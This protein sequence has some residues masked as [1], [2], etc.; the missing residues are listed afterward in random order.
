MNISSKKK[1]CLVS[2]C[3][4]FVI[5]SIIYMINGIVPFGNNTLLF[6]DFKNQYFSMIVN[7]INRIYSHKSLIY[8]FNSGL[9]FPI[10]RDF[11][12][13]LSSPLNIIFI[14]ANKNN[15][16]LLVSILIGLRPILSSLTM[17]Y[18]L[19]TKFKNNNILYVCL[20][21]LY[22]FS[23]YY[24]DYY[25]NIM[26]TDSMV[27][28]P[29][30][31][32]GLESII[33]NNKWKLYTIS[34]S[35]MIFSNYYIAY[36][37]CLF[38][39]VYFIF[40]SIYKNKMH[41][42]SLKKDLNDISRKFLIYLCSSIFSLLICS[43]VFNILLNISDSLETSSSRYLFLTLQYP[44]T[45]KS[46]L[47][48][49][50][51]GS[52][53]SRLFSEP[54][55]SPPI[56]CGILSVVLLIIYIFNNK[57]SLRNKIC[58]LGLLLF[59]IIT[60]FTGP[61]DSIFNLFHFPNDFP[62]RYSFLYIFIL[63]VISSYSVNNIYKINIKLIFSLCIFLISLIITI[64]NKNILSISNINIIINIIL[65]ISYFILI[66]YMKD[67]KYISLIFIILVSLECIIT[68]N[69]NILLYY[70][71]DNIY[72]NS[73]Q[74]SINYISNND[75]NFYRID[76]TYNDTNMGYKY[77]YY[78]VGYYTSM[79][80]LNMGDFMSRIGYNACKLSSLGNYVTPVNGL[81][82]D[83]KYVVGNINSNYYNKI[84]DNIYKSNYESSLMFGINKQD[85]NIKYDNNNPFINLNNLVNNIS[86]IDNIFTEIKPDNININN[87][88]VT[89]KFNNTDNIFIYVNIDNINY[90]IVNNNL[91]YTNYSYKKD[92]IDSN[93]KK[94]EYKYMHIILLNSD[95]LTISYTN[96]DK[97]LFYVYKLDDNKYKLFADYINTNKFNMNVF[98]ED[99]IDGNI[100]L[101][102]DR[103]MYVSIPYDKNIDVYVD[104]KKVNTY[105]FADVLLSFDIDK[106][107]HNIK[108]KYNMSFMIPGIVLS[109]V[110]ILVFILICIYDKKKKC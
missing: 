43:F 27:L 88:I 38:T 15:I 18:Y 40:Y 86:N 109:L 36:M 73:Y 30:I 23:G 103:Q 46:F 59:F 101:D 69:S 7:I 60:F 68:F 55:L 56:T 50:L 49:H 51:T 71:T 22:A 104:D 81:L 93:I 96:Y 31:I 19:S 64:L 54:L 85:N 24:C 21:V 57:I 80:Y 25:F 14:F 91:Y 72:D 9:G 39:I 2:V 8:T 102:K 74:D 28:L 12:N 33:N 6:N 95:T 53:E 98:N 76:N 82:F 1:L 48:H 66:Y 83:V 79:T 16:Y 90:F 97:D 107:Y 67:Y 75:N 3:V 99:Y 77:D 58:Y 5:I 52:I 13:Y 70:K 26:W 61:I 45:I 17:C 106:G 41:K 44:I 89:Y 20:S 34:L 94:Q 29:L 35:I 100:N 62:F 32:L 87:N 105:K 47:I 63:I 92:N 42:E 65:V 37:I 4:S 110:S 84:S 108:I 11:I 10:Y 78:D